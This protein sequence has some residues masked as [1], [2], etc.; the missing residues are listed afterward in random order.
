MEGINNSPKTHFDHYKEENF[1][2]NT[3]QQNR[4]DYEKRNDIKEFQC[5]RITNFDKQVAMF[6]SLNTGSLQDSL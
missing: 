6:F 2:I 1:I 4:I 5:I 3:V